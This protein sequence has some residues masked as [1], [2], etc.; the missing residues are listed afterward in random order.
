[1]ESGQGSAAEAEEPHIKLA[2]VALNA[3]ALHVH[4]ALRGRRADQ[5]QIAT[6]YEETPETVAISGDLG[7]SGQN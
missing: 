2:L 3:L 1:M 7:V 6:G 5:L 4:L